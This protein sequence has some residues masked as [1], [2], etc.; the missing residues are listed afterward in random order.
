MTTPRITGA[1]DTRDD[2]G[3]GTDAPL[4]LVESNTTGT[5]RQFAQR[6]RACGAEPVLPATDPARYPY[7][8]E[9]GLRTVVVDTAD[10]DALWAAVPTGAAM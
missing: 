5:G 9:D 1:D 6:A 7:A 8:A 4:L 3:P 2:E 10:G